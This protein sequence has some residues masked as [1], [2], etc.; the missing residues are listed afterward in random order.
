M[1][2]DVFWQWMLQTDIAGGCWRYD[3]LSRILGK[4]FTMSE[5]A[6]LRFLLGQATGNLNNNFICLYL[7]NISNF[8]YQIIFNFINIV[9]I[10]PINN[11]SFSLRIFAL[12]RNIFKRDGRKKP[13]IQSCPQRTGIIIPYWLLHFVISVMSVTTLY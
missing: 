13:S 12:K 5:N 3:F 9:K 6:Q 2:C 10:N 11:I 1:L 4:N 8:I 7:V